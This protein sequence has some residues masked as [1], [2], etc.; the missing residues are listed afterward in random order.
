MINDIIGEKRIDLS[1][2]I[3]S[4][5]TRR[6]ITVISMFNDNIQYEVVKSHTIIDDI[7]PG[8][9]KLILSNTY[10]GKELISIS[11]GMIELT[12]FENDEQVIKTNKLRGITEMILNLDEL[13][14]TVN[15]ED[16]RPSNILYRHHVTD[17]YKFT[18]L[19]T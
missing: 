6:E 9:K 13:D 1:C 14:N 10:T 7:S 19:A 5:N 15:L 17:S 8:N 3:H 4:F 11:E 12:Q 18:Q 16:G 2:P